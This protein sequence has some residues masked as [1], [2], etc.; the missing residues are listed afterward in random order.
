MRRVDIAATREGATVIVKGLANGE[1]VVT[2]GHSR[3]VPGAKV[4]IKTAGEKPSAQK[5][6]SPASAH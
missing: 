2:D 1:S 3:L 5:P 6:A 4:K